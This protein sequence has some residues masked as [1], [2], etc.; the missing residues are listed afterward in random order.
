LQRFLLIFQKY[1]SILDIYNLDVSDPKAQKFSESVLQVKHF[2]AYRLYPIG[3]KD[4][5]SKSKIVFTKTKKFKDIGRD[6]SD[7]IEDPLL[8]LTP[9]SFSPYLQRVVTQ[10][11]PALFLFHNQDD[12]SMSLRILAQFERYKNHINFA[13]FKNPPEDIR[14]QFTVEKL[15]KIAVVFV[16]DLDRKDITLDDGVQTASYT[17]KFSYNELRHYLDTVF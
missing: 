14:S 5:K 10:R 1:S 16:R 15:P 6:I 9:V 13:H 17:G 11:K 2:P 8:A 4:K 12:I 7:L 3:N